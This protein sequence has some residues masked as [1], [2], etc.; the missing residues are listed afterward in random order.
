MPSYIASTPSDGGNDAAAGGSLAAIKTGRLG[1]LGRSP[2]KARQCRM[3][4]SAHSKPQLSKPNI[5]FYGRVNH[6]ARLAFGKQKA[7]EEIM[8]DYSLGCLGWA[9]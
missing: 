1:F 5:K 3:S 6:G 4:D 2:L 9:D 8:C 7:M